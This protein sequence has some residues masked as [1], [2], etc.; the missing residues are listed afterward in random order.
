MG[1][2]TAAETRGRAL[3]DRGKAERE[4]RSGEELLAVGPARPRG[5]N[6]WASAGGI[7]PCLVAAETSLEEEG[8]E[9]VGVEADGALPLLFLDGGI[10]ACGGRSRGWALRAGLQ[11]TGPSPLW[12]SL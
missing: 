6:R 1:L 12:I 4:E 11:P 9:D 2:S 8:E 3:R 5:S 7:R 10:L